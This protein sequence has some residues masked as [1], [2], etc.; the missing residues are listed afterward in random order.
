MRTH[1]E[2]DSKP[3]TRTEYNLLL[4]RLEDLEDTLSLLQAQDKGTSADAWTDVLVTRMLDGEHPLRLWR[5]HRGMTLDAISRATGV[6]AGYLS[7]IE[8]GKKPG[9]VAT[10]RKCATALGVDLDDVVKGAAE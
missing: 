2:V 4:Q 9:S 7:E 6:A 10:L 3:V 1:S 5:E 8:N